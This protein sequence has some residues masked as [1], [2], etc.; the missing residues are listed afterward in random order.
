MRCT[1]MRR[2][3]PSPVPCGSVPSSIRR[4][5]NSMAR[6]SATSEALKVIS[7]MRLTI[8]CD[9]FGVSMRTAGLICTTSTSSVS[10]VR[11]NG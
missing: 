6:Y 7:L 11:K 5:T 9:E 2:Y 10:V 3:W 8:S 1:L 4:L